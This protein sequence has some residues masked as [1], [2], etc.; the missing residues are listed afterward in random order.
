MIAFVP[1]PV[2]ATCEHGRCDEP[3][4]VAVVGRGLG[5]LAPDAA[6]QLGPLRPLIARCVA[7]DRA[8]RFAT[9]HAL[10]EAL[11][12]I[13]GHR[14]PPLGL[15]DGRLVWRQVEAG[16]GLL[17]LGLADRALAPFKAALA[18][19]HRTGGERTTVLAACIAAIE[20]GPTAQG[21]PAP[22]I[23]VAPLDA[24]VSSTGPDA[25]ELM[26]ARREL[27][28]SIAAFRVSAGTS[29]ERASEI[30]A[31]LGELRVAL[32]RGESKVAVALLRAPDHL[33]DPVAQ[34]LLASLLAFEGDHASALAAYAHAHLLGAEH[35]PRALL[36]QAD[37]LLA[38]GDASAALALYHTLRQ[39]HADLPGVQDGRIHALRQLGRVEEAE[40]LQAGE[41]AAA[42]ASS[43]ARVATIPLSARP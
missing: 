40:G 20:R 28:R 19:E 23:P 25:R 33:G 37:V 2:G 11:V 41:I 36:G 1:P 8:H 15:R 9:L 27:A 5:A 39:D 21:M 31:H 16:L 10:I 12:S 6:N 22:M 3:A 26:R 38:M 30:P 32:S 7:E 42:A 17:A 14:R 34:L 35:R 4:L 43:D 18:E 29:R 24:R 13:G